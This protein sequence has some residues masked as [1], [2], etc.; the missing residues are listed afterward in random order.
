MT[1]NE[2]TGDIL[3]AAIKRILSPWI[4]RLGCLSTSAWRNLS[5]NPINLCALCLSAPLRETKTTKR[6]PGFGAA[7]GGSCH[8][9]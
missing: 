6:T 8:L 9:I 2:I 3:D 1:E 5:I 4:S 7:A